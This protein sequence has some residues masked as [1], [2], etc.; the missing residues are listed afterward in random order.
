MEKPTALAHE[1]IYSAVENIL[2]DAPRGKLLDAPAGHGALAER[3]IQHGFDVSCCDL[4]PEIFRLDGVEIRQGNLDGRLPYENGEFEIAVCVE[5]LEHIENP[6]NAIREFARLLTPGGLFIVSVPNI[7]NIEE[8]LKWLLG[9]YTSHFKPISKS[10]L[11]KARSDY[12]GMEEIALHVNPVGYSEVRFLLERS[13]FALERTYIDKRKK[14]GWT[15]APIVALIRLASRFSSQKRRDER[16][17]N[18][19][20]SNEVL[21]GGNTLI[22]KARKL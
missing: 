14:N 9:G 1:A 10:A 8:R 3:L 12:P 21:A 16:W 13:G 18:E 4:Y 11:A 20:N 6:A 19:L 2:R 5:G 22:F 17:T 15:Y 7:M